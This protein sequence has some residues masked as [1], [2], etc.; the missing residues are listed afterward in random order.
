MGPYGK[1]SYLKKKASYE[2]QKI[3]EKIFHMKVKK[4][5]KKY[6]QLISNL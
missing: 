4:I 1:Q 6:L 3:S 5:M 2:S